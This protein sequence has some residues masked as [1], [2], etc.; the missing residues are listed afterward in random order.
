V[1]ATEADEADDRRAIATYLI[2]T[3]GLSAIFW[4]I[5]IRAG[6]LEVRGGLYVMLLM[7]CPGVA[8]IAS[9]LIHTRSLRGLGWKWGSTRDQLI[10]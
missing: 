10:G 4:T 3:L 5:V 9:Q 1:H 8:G 6:T 2:L 7:W